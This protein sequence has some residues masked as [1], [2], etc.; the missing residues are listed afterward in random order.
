MWIGKDPLLSGWNA[1]SAS[2][3]SNV[4]VSSSGGSDM[5]RSVA[6]ALPLLTGHCVE[7]KHSML[8]AIL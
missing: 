4:L 6:M 2:A 5:F 3:S 7:G 1:E 8:L